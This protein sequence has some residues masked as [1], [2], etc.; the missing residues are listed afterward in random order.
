MPKEE[1]IEKME[2]E[3]RAGG[4]FSAYIA[5]CLKGYLE[6]HGEEEEKFLRPDK[7]VNGCAAHIIGEARARYMQSG[8][9][10][11]SVLADR[12]VAAEIMDYYGLSYPV[13]LADPGNGY[14]SLQ[15]ETKADREDEA[16]KPKTEQYTEQHIEHS[17]APAAERKPAFPAARRYTPEDEGDLFPSE[18]EQQA[19]P[20][21]KGIMDISLDDLFQEG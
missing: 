10:R 20:E 19:K 21:K 16:G 14:F 5:I 8:K 18:P 3:A 9:D 4:P 11:C 7:T 17:A 15:G 1:T 12:E 6:A 2:R 13:G